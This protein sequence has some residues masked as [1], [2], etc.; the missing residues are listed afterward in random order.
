MAKAAIKS[1]KEKRDFGKAIMKAWQDAID[2]NAANPKIDRQALLTALDL[3]LDKANKGKT[4][5][6][7]EY[8]IVFDTDLDANTR[9][10]WLTIPTPDRE[11]AGFDDTWQKYKN[12]F[13][14]N[15]SESNKK[16]REIE[17]AE[18]VLFG[19]GR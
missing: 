5:R 15:L 12:A 2:A 3:I 11:K 10:V 1:G 16:K 9:L 18:A 6:T 4:D 14:D 19:C 7:I 17:I 13:Y 8:D